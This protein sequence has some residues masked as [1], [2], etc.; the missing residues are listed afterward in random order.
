MEQR[1]ML[2]KGI[3]GYAEKVV[4]TIHYLEIKNKRGLFK[5]LHSP[6]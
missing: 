3:S 1:N 4:D 6:L 2:K 5:T